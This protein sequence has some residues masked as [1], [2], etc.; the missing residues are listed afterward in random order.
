MIDKFIA[1]Y[2]PCKLWRYYTDC[3]HWRYYIHC[4]HW[5]Q[6]EHW[7]DGGHYIHCEPYNHCKHWRHY[8]HCK[9]WRHYKHCKHWG[10][11]IQCIKQLMRKKNIVSLHKKETV[12]RYYRKS[13]NYQAGSRS[14]Q[15]I[16]L[17]NNLIHNAEKIYI[18]Y[19]IYSR[20]G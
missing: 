20:I 15:L 4:K 7:K 11:F 1:Q 19:I 17:R 13:H 3:I 18:L 8:E 6:Y 12:S 2:N 5:G 14:I 10:Y 16:R 9:H